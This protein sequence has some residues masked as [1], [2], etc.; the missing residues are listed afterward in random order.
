M[1]SFGHYFE[2]FAALN[3]AYIVGN[4]FFKL[5]AAIIDRHFSKVESQHK[6]LSEILKG[7]D[8]KLKKLASFEK[9]KINPN[10]LKEK[11]TKKSEFQTKFEILKGN[12]ES[13]KTENQA[14][15]NFNL[16]CL[17]GTLYCILILSLNGWQIDF[18]SEYYSVSFLF[19]NVISIIILSWILG[20]FAMFAKRRLYPT[21]KK[22]ILLF[23]SN[24][25]LSVLFYFFIHFF[26]VFVKSDYWMKG[27]YIVSMLIPAFQFLY[28]FLIISGNT[29]R[30]AKKMLDENITYKK[31]LEDF[32]NQ[33][34]GGEKMLLNLVEENGTPIFKVK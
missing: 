21:Y 9:L 34:D 27:N 12:L 3:S 22:V 1:E 2:F 30:L 7:L 19:F 14:S 23:F 17:F 25:L 8:E 20:A 32:V 31:E 28:Y 10:F 15:R 26:F 18:D 11:D 6:Y 24:L 13:A 4:E 16:V 33:V 5:L 29:K